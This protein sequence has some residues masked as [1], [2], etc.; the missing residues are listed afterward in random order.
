MAPLT[1]ATSLAIAASFGLVL[2]GCANDVGSMFGA[3]T[4]TA[5]IPERPKV[6][7]AC[8]TLTSQID[9]LRKEGIADRVE[10]AAVKKYKMTPADL[11]KA[12]QL[13]R[14]NAEFKDKCSATSVTTALVA[15]AGEAEAKVRSQAAVSASAPISSSGQ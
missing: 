12:A 14:A 7:P 10:K 8:V 5:S 3:T 15:P 13:N 2:A 11:T 9:T 1:R 6:D 4:T